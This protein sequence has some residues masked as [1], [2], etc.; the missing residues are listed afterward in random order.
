MICDL[1]STGAGPG[2][3]ALNRSH[4]SGVESLPFRLAHLWHVPAPDLMVLENL[5][6]VL[7]KPGREPCQVRGA[8]SGCFRD[9]WPLHRDAKD[10]AL[11]LAKKVIHSGAS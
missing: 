10:I 8:E 2:A 6:G 4:P 11:E 7:P 9:R 1:L 5:I 3:R